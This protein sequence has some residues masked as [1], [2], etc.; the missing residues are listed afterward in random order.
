MNAANK[1]VIVTGASSG[2][3]RATSIELAN[4]GYTVHLIGRNNERLT[5]LHTQLSTNGTHS[6]FYSLDLTDQ[7]AVKKIFAA[8]YSNV[9]TDTISGLVNSAGVFYET[10]ILDYQDSSWKDIMEVNFFGTL[11]PCLAL[12]PR[13]IGQHS[14]SI[15]T[16]TSV[17]AFDGIMNYAAYSV[18][19]GA[20]NS[21]TKTLALEGAASNVRVNAVVPG[22]TDTEMTHDRIQL[23]AQTYKNKVPLQ[24]PASPSEI[25]K[26]I[27]FLLSDAASYITGQSIHVNGGWRL[28]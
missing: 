21:L 9:G 19:K 2:I 1:H 23:N 25:A 4:Q 14:G 28:A 27:M 16:V 10:D 26:P 12:L 3:G 17:D 8:I 22:I 18:S 7:E 15:V 6:F 5:D 24:R 11:Y 20:V 13:L